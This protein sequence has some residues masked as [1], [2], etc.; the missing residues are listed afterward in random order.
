MRT[1]AS[2][3]V[4]GA[5]SPLELTVSLVAPNAAASVLRTVQRSRHKPM[6][7]FRKW[8]I[9]HTNTRCDVV[10]AM[11]VKGGA[12]SNTAAAIVPGTMF[13]LD[14][15]GQRVGRLYRARSAT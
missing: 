9:E 14:L 8:T 12:T 7:R 5:L 15:V 4:P 11:R 13:V 2:E 3:L 6:G 1:S 10:R